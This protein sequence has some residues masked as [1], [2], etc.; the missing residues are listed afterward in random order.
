[1]LLSVAAVVGAKLRARE[2]QNQ[3]QAALG[4]RLLGSA[5]ARVRRR[6]SWSSSTGRVVVVVVSVR[7]EAIAWGRHRRRV[8]PSVFVRSL[9]APALRTRPVFFI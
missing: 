7:L 8:V 4:S 5:R 2:R 6:S 1:M 3:K 9:I